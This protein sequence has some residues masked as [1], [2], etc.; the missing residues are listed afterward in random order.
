MGLVLQICDTLGGE[1]GICGLAR[2]QAGYC[3]E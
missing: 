2:E 3:D 1:I